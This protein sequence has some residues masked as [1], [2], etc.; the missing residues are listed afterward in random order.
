MGD[1]Y[2]M[3][4]ICVNFDQEADNV[5]VTIGVSTGG[6]PNETW[7]KIDNFRLW[8]LADE[9]SDGISAAVLSQPHP[10]SS[11]I[12]DLTGRMV[13][14][15]PNCHLPHGIYIRNHKKYIVK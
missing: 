6:A 2:P 15:D 7:F 3:Q 8:L 9:V 13:A 1:T 14:T 5:P 4:T 12:H 11:A 10:Y